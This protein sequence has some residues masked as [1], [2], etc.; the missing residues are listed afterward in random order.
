MS[1]NNAA[2][3]EMIVN[4]EPDELDA[5]PDDAEV[6]PD[7]DT[8]DRDMVFYNVVEAYRDA[9]KKRENY[10][11]YGPLTVIITGILFLTLMFTLDDKI[12][13]LILWVVTDLYIVALMVRAEYKLHRFRVILGLEKDGEEEPGDEELEET[14]EVEG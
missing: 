11:K 10:K 2:E 8:V 9:F 5:E 7:F 6:V 13:F 1:E 3:A 14:G 4:T 12:M